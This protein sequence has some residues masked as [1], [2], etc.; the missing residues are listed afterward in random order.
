M[1]TL[2][3]TVPTAYQLRSLLK[4]RMGATRAGNGSY[5]AEQKFGS[6]DEA[7]DYLKGIAC[8]YN[9]NDPDGTEERM[10]DMLRD[11]EDACCLVLDG[12]M[13]EVVNN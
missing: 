10:E 13:C 12:A 7:K 6:E 3:A 2:R 8:D 5:F 4:F 11:I 9:S 1:V